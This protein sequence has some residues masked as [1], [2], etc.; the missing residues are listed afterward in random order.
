M[1]TFKMDYTKSVYIPEVALQHSKDYK[2]QT[3]KADLAKKA[4]LDGIEGSSEPI[5]VSMMKQ[6]RA[7]KQQIAYL[8]S[9][10]EKQQLSSQ[11]NHA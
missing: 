3:S 10:M 11:I 2:E 9:Q 1:D 7:Q 4:G 8:Q 5:I 6:L